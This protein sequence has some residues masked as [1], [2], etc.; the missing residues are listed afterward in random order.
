M[1]V[2]FLKTF[3]FLVFFPLSCRPHPL[4]SPVK[5]SPPDFPTSLYNT[6]V[7]LD[8]LYDLY[9]FFLTSIEFVIS[10]YAFLSEDLKNNKQVSE[11][12]WH[13]SLWIW[14]ASFSI[15]RYVSIHLSAISCSYFSLQLYRIPSC[16]CITFS[17]FIYQLKTLRLFLFSRY[18]EQSGNQHGWKTV[19]SQEKSQKS[20]Q[21]NI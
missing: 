21:K 2:I 5:V 3:L 9:Q 17:W 4:L 18:C 19:I 1:I 10:V 15:I 13:F 11:S 8:T 14:V 20:E 7:L 12:I 6:C 16:I